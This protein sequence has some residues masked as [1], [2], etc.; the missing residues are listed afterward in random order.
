MRLQRE[1][2]NAQR[3]ETDDDSCSSKIHIFIFEEFEGVRM[4]ALC[5][6]GSTQG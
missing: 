1:S 5:R 6:D 3:E 2:A 4:L